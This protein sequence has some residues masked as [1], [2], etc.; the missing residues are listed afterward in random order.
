LNCDSIAHWYRWLEYAGFGVELERRRC[1]FLPDVTGAQRALLLGEGDGRFLGKFVDRSRATRIDCVDASARMLDLARSR[2]G[3]ERVAYHHADARAIPFPRAGYDLVVTHFFLDCFDEAAVARLVER[4][5]DAAAPHA[6]W[7]VS[8]FRQPVAGWRAAWAKAWL[9]V[10]YLFFRLSTGLRTRRLV[11]H[12]PMLASRG[13]RLAREES[14]R[15][16]LLA[17]ELWVR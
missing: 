17:S 3:V 9:G 12:R 5:A 4:V 8:E 15:L 2:A 16:G 7:L 13:F 10:L 1:A 11:D 6:R 14:S